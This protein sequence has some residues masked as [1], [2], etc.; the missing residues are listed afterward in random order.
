MFCVNMN[1]EFEKTSVIEKCGKPRCFKSIDRRPHYKKAWMT[2]EIYQ[3]WLQNF[4]RKMQRQNRYAL[5]ILDNAPSHPKDV[6][7]SNMK[8]IFLP[9]NAT[10]K[11]QPLDQGIIKAIKTIY[12]KLLL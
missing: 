7:V 12:R 10:S 3:R 5:L 6:K 11:F 4:D 1:G 9:A 8:V 2:F